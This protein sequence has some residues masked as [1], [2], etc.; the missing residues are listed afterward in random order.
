MKQVERLIRVPT[1]VLE[2]A[3]SSVD[4]PYSGHFR[5]TTRETIKKT[6]GASQM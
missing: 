2:T 6:L 1:Y 4:V 3:E 5:A